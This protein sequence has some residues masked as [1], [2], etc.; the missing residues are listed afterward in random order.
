MPKR[1]TDTEKWK[2]PF[3]RGLKAPYKLLWLY[4]CD[5]CDHAGVW[6]VDLEV[7]Q[8]RIGEKINEADA[9]RVFGDKIRVFEAGSKWFI[10]SFIDFQYPTGLNP[11]NKAHAGVIQILKKYKLDE[12]PSKPLECPLQG[13]KDKDMDMVMDKDMEMDTETDK[14]KPRAKIEIVNPFG[15]AGRHMWQ[16]WKTYKRDEHRKTYKSEKTEQQAIQS[17][18]E[19]AGG[20]LETASKI[21]SQ[22]IANQWQGLFPLKNL[23]NGKQQP[24]SNLRADVQA[25]FDRRFAS[26]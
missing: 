1:F 24:G 3:I 2:K 16:A 20:N 17:L 4:I 21:I 13:A 5:D 22:S 26:R 18:Y 10:P 9:I 19:M 6:Q 12:A 7:A 15:E 14:E 8:L 11:A 25:E 23:S